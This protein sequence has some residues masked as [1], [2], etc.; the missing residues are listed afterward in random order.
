MS[1]LWRR[2]EAAGISVD[3]QLELAGEEIENG[4]I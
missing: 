2:G 3:Y 1:S 4:K